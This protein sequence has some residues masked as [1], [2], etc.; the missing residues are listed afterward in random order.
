VPRDMPSPPCLSRVSGQNGGSYA[1]FWVMD[2][3]AAR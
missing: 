2:D 1:G 3:Q